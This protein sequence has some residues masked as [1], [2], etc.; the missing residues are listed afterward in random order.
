MLLRDEEIAKLK[1]KSDYDDDRDDWVIPPF[2]LKGKEVSL[3]TLG[4]KNGYDHMEQEKE[5][6]DMIIEGGGKGGKDSDDEYED[7]FEKSQ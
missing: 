6:R 7:D 4:K 2:V 5:N 1:M 3:P